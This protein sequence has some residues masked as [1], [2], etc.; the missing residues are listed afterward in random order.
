MEREEAAEAQIREK[1]GFVKQRTNT[2]HSSDCYGISGRISSVAAL[3][4]MW[5]SYYRKLSVV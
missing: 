2:R 5:Y 3:P 4:Q 1:H